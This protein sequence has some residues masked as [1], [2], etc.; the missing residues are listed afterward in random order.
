VSCGSNSTKA[1]YFP[2]D[3][4]PK[5]V[6]NIIFSGDGGFQGSMI[7]AG[8]CHDL[9][10]VKQELNEMVYSPTPRLTP[11]ESTSCLRCIPTMD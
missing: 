2:V 5:N 7:R 6:V 8:T 10:Q 4:D 9:S 11:K 1:L 3:L